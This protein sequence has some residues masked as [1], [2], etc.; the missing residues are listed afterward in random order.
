MVIAFLN[1]IDEV[2]FVRRTGYDLYQ[3]QKAD[4][5]SNGR[6]GCRETHQFILLTSSAYASAKSQLSHLM[7][8]MEFDIATILR[9]MALKSVFDRLKDPLR[10]LS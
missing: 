7:G 9:E 8:H 10:R 6:L 4:P 3:Q 2:K 1:H 5:S